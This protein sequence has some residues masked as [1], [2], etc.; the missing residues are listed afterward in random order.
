MD[1]LGNISL[2]LV[3]MVTTIVIL[4]ATYLFIV[5]PVLN[6]T[7]NAFK[8]F[9]EPISRALDMSQQQ[10]G[11]AV[12]QAKRQNHGAVHIRG[13]GQVGLKRAQ[14]LLG[15]VQRAHGDVNRMSACAQ[16]LSP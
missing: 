11:Q 9:N 13:T 10:L 3:G 16:R 5:K 1:F 15:C 12:T 2:R 4:G 8:S 14:K 7:N 6:T